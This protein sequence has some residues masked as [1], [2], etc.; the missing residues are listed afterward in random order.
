[1]PCP[2]CLAP[3]VTPFFT[4]KEMSYFTCPACDLIFLHPDQHPSQKAEESRY[5]QHQNSPEDEGYR[6]FLSPLVDEIAQRLSAGDVGLDFG[7]GPGP[8]IPT[9]L[10]ERGFHAVTYDPFFSPH[11][12]RLEKSY[13]FITCTETAEHFFDPR[14]EFKLLNSILAE[15]G[16]LG[17]MTQFFDDKNAFATSHYRRDPTHVCFYST[18]TFQW[19]GQTHGWHPHFSR[20]NIVLFQKPTSSN[21]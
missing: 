1:M 6:A 19:V 7:S 17:I 18:R 15:G 14:A 5:R 10:R 9:M 8:A 4:E 16:W 20:K 13:P 12:E 3:E 11:P 21:L 2:L